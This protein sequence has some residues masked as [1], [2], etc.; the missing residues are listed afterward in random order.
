MPTSFLAHIE[1][2]WAA[3]YRKKRSE[4]DFKVY[5]K[6]DTSHAHAHMHTLACVCTHLHGQQLANSQQHSGE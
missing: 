3:A 5:M 1:E 6:T 2:M 4:K